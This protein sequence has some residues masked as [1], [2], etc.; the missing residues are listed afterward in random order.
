MKDETISVKLHTRSEE[1]ST[2]VSSNRQ[3]IM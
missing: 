3:M 2:S 1:I